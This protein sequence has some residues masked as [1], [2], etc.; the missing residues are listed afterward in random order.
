M[1]LHQLG[2]KDLSSAFVLR[3]ATSSGEDRERE[4]EKEVDQ[5][6]AQATP[7]QVL[8]QVYDDW[9][10]EDGE[11]DLNEELFSGTRGCPLLPRP[12]F[13]LEIGALEAIKQ[14]DLDRVV[15]QSVSKGLANAVLLRDGDVSS[16]AMMRAASALHPLCSRVGVKF[17]VEDRLDLVAAEVADG[18]LFN[19]IDTEFAMPMLRSI[20]AERRREFLEDNDA[21]VSLDED[22]YDVLNSRDERMEDPQRGGGGRGRGGERGR[23]GGRGGAGGGRGAEEDANGLP[24]G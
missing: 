16:A 7:S 11:E 13:L 8:P 19:G 18:I 2:H 3:A 23:G 14:R 24:G 6:Q 15:E 20:E 22:A 9:D 12:L 17:F 4:K 5:A 21:S 1:R 10:G